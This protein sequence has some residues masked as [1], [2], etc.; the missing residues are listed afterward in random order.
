ME[1]LSGWLL[2]GSVL[3]G[4]SE[5]SAPSFLLLA[6][7]SLNTKTKLEAIVL[8]S[9]PTPTPKDTWAVGGEGPLSLMIWVQMWLLHCDPEEVTFSL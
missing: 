1:C 3:E 2:V 7:G 6:C 5:K 4:G 9:S 8:G